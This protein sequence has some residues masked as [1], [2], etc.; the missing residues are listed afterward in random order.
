MEDTK[1]AA[2]KNIASMKKG[3]TQQ[4][5]GDTDFAS[6]IEKSSLIIKKEA[7]LLKE[8]I[9]K[10][11][12]TTKP[13][14]SSNKLSTSDAIKDVGEKTSQV[15]FDIFKL[16]LLLPLLLNDKV[17]ALVGGFFKKFLEKLG[18]AAPIVDAMAL[19][20]D[21]I[22]YILGAYFGFKIWKSVKGAFDA[23]MELARVTGIAADNTI[24]QANAVDT[25][26]KTVRDQQGRLR[27]EKGR[28]VSEKKALEDG[29]K[30]ASDTAK[31]GIKDAKK[32]MKAAKKLGKFSILEK[33]KVLKDKVVPKLLS[34][35]KNFIKAIPGVGTLIGLG[36]ILYDLWSIGSD[37][38]DVFLGGEEKE[39]QATP[40]KKAPTSSVTQK[41]PAASATASSSATS[42]GKPMASGSAAATATATST[43][44]TSSTTSNTSSAGTGPTSAASPASPPAISVPP[45]E[46][47]P[48]ISETSQEILFKEEMN[49]VTQV[50]ITNIDNSKKTNIAA[51]PGDKSPPSSVYFTLLA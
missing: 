22:Q 6:S 9:L 39:Q 45:V 20:I 7:A 49:N 1:E 30:K 34:L 51:Q 44:S 17:K 43:N 48:M 46:T 31:T 14:V 11:F 26:R 42:A 37:I 32:D 25:E 12:I 33:F 21:N 41:A 8:S 2:I 28:F 4:K 13:V 35:G 27:D 18:V 24:T 50:S 5:K 19:A 3:I 47:A 38:Y 10:F 29:V 15:G 23:I 16:A 40:V 36:V